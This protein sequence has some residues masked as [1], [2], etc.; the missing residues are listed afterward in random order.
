[1]EHIADRAM[2]FGDISFDGMRQRVHTGCGGQTFRHRG[3]H[4]RIDNSNLGNIVRVNA[5]EFPLLLNIGNNVIDRDLCCGACGRRN[6]N[7]K[8]CMLFRRRNAF[9]RANVR[10]FRI[11]DDDTDRFRGIHC[12]AAADRND[13][14]RFCLLERCNAGLNVFNRRIRLDVAVNFIRKACLIQQIRHLLRDTELQK[15]RVGCNKR[16]L[17]SA[18]YKRRDDVFNC[19]VTMIGNGVQNDTICHTVFSPLIHLK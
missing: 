9:E 4:I 19:A 17:A 3:H 7:R 10:K 6:G 11:V 18:G 14:I 2:S 16:L 12:A 8:D 5:N 13:A 1:M 15:T